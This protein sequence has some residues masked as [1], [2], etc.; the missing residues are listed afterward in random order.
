MRARREMIRS[1]GI[2]GLLCLLGACGGQVVVGAGG[3]PGSGGTGSGGT[4]GAPASCGSAP[5]GGDLT[6]VWSVQK[7]C[8]TASQPFPV[9]CSGAVIKINEESVTGT[10]EFDASGAYKESV[11]GTL[12]VQIVMP[13]GCKTSAECTAYAATLQSEGIL[14]ATCSFDGAC[15][16][17]STMTTA[18]NGNN[19]STG[20][21][22]VS[23]TSLTTT[24]SG[25]G[26]PQALGYC[27]SGNTLTLIDDT[28]GSTARLVLTRPPPS[29]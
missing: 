9:G 13:A 6:G 20:T 26:T 12:S 10:Y 29:G 5:C 24:L 28:P 27:V 16:C 23:G 8:G 25:G 11:N 14:G 1:V 21:Y 22:Q 18:T 4:G 17:D 2:F 3:A 19:V 7:F 15:T